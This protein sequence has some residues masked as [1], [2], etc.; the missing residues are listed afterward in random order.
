M[1]PFQ[2]LP[3]MMLSSQ[4]LPFTMEL[5]L[6][7]FKIL[8]K[9]PLLKLN[10]WPSLKKLLWLELKEN[11]ILLSPMD[12]ILLT[13]W[14]LDSNLFIGMEF[15]PITKWLMLPTPDSLMVFTTTKPYLSV[16]YFFYHM[17]WTIDGN[18]WNKW[19]FSMNQCGMRF[20]I[21]FYYLIFLHKDLVLRS[22]C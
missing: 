7:L 12:T 22:F 11:R 17:W 15:M 10:I 18:S 5:L 2:L 14:T 3:F 9:L 4:L 20:Y 16:Q 13:S 6:N 8:L 21:T 19:L 1:L